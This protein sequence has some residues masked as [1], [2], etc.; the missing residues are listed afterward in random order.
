MEMHFCAR[1]Q[2]IYIYKLLSEPPAEGDKLSGS[3]DSEEKMT[4]S[5]VLPTRFDPRL[6]FLI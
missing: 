2:Q 5:K 3:D 6:L 1:R 4:M